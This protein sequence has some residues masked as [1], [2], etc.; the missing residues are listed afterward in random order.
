MGCDEY[1]KQ[2]SVSKKLFEANW[3][4]C[5]SELEGNPM[6]CREIRSGPGHKIEAIA[7]VKPNYGRC[8]K[9]SPTCR[10]GLLGYFL[11]SSKAHLSHDN[12]L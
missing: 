1:T 11:S 5:Y 6:Y 8:Y 10:Y 2:N 4:N 7:I 12:N 3:R 9:L